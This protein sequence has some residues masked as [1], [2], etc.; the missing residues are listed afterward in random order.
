MNG[1][2][3]KRNGGLAQMDG[4]PPKT[5][6]SF[7]ICTG[8][9]RERNGGFP[10]LNGCVWESSGRCGAV[11]RPRLKRNLKNWKIFRRATRR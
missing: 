2:V 4:C 8:S 10:P 9:F 7:L 5:T 6:G 1:C 3:W 11:H